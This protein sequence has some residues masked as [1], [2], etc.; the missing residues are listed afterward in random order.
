M[1]F[2]EKLTVAQ[3]VRKF[4]NFF[5]FGT[6]MFHC[7]VHN[8]HLQVFKLNS[9]MQAVFPADLINLQYAHSSISLR[10]QIM[11]PLGIKFSL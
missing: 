1:E 5:F 2:L 7:L 3:A 8:S 4:L 6:Q 10:A 11:K 9:C